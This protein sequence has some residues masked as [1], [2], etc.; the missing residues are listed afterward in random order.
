DDMRLALNAERELPELA[1]SA[2]SSNSK[3]YSVIGSPP[4]RAVFERAFG[5]PKSFGAINIDK[6]VET[7]RT[8]TAASFGSSDLEQFKEPV[9]LEKLVRIFLVQSEVRASR[10]SITMG[11]TALT[12]LQQSIAY[13]RKV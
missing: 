13:L 3:W 7:L 4:L 12:L 6:Q 2:A 11:Q 9:Q 1:K 10:E 8:R 5:L